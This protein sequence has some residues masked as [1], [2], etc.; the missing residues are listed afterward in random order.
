[1]GHSSWEGVAFLVILALSIVVAA[2]N[3]IGGRG[4]GGDGYDPDEP[5]VYRGRN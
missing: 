3:V 2:V 4:G 1:M 5:P